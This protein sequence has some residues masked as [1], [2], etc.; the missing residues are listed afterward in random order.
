MSIAATPTLSPA[1]M[2]ALRRRLP[3]YQVILLN[4]P[5]N[6][7]RK[8]AEIL[9]QEVSLP[10][11]EAWRI[12]REAHTKGQATVVVCVKEWAERYY[13]RLTLRGLT[14]RIELA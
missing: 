6:D 9:T 14:C 11:Q 2:E 5:D 1:E 12:S 3:R 13:G 10:W 7:L 4:D 8:V